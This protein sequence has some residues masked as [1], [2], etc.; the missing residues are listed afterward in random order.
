MIDAEIHLNNVLTLIEQNDLRVKL[1]ER[2]LKGKLGFCDKDNRE[3]QIFE[4][5]EDS[6][7][8]FVLVR[9]CLSLLHPQKSGKWIKAKAYSAWGC[10]TPALRAQLEAFLRGMP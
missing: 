5:L 6:T 2:P 8:A 4:K 3:I 7:K 10:S 9:E 1:V